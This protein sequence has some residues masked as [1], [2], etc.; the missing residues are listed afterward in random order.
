MGVV[1]VE[2]GVEWEV[3][4]K[5]WVV[6]VVGITRKVTKKKKKAKKKEIIDF[7]TH[8]YFSLLFQDFPSLR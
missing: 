7:L 3:F 8:F 6:G 5:W 2:E 1:G 4:G